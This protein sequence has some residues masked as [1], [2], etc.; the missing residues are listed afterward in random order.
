MTEKTVNSSEPKNKTLQKISILKLTFLTIVTLG[1]Y[2]PFWYLRQ[3]G[4]INSLQSN[5]KIAKSPF[6]FV[7][8]L[9]CVSAIFIVLSSFA[10]ASADPLLAAMYDAMEKIVSLIGLV[11][12]LNQSLK[13]KRI[14]NDHYNEYLKQNINFSFWGVMFFTYFYLQYKI[15][16]LP[17][18]G[19]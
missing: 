4:G 5:F 7:I 15:N 18:E 11:I 14:L 10:E 16:R 2:Q 9:F 3:R 19:T 6:I 13:I 1:W 12:I 17:V 8:V